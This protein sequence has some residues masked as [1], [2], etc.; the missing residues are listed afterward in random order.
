MKTE[1]QDTSIH[2]ELEP[3]SELVFILSN[4]FNE[5]EPSFELYQWPIESLRW[6]AFVAS[7]VMTL[8]PDAVSDTAINA[9]IEL[10]LVKIKKL[11]GLAPIK[12]GD[13]SE[14]AKLIL[15]ILGEAG[16]DEH[17]STLILHSLVEAATAVQSKVAGQAQRLI[18]SESHALIKRLTEFLSFSRLDSHTATLITTRWLQDI[19]N[20]PVLLETES[21]NAFIEDMDISTEELIEAADELD[22]NLALIDEIVQHWYEN[23]LAADQLAAELQMLQ[24]DEHETI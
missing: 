9:L 3:M 17:T 8:A 1:T 5:Y 19:L 23:K 11:A 21:I 13:Y 22:I 12:P 16:I 20:L 10:D 2:E 6:T 15:A 18:R 4:L 7:V 14:R 24:E